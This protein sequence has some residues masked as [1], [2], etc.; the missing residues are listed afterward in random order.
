[1]IA[2][3]PNCSPLEPI[4]KGSYTSFPH[5]K[6][7]SLRGLTTCL[8]ALSK[9]EPDNVPSLLLIADGIHDEQGRYIVIDFPLTIIGESKDGCTI[10]GGL[11]MK[12]K[13]EDDVTV[14]HLTISQSK[15]Y[16]VYGDGGM[17]FHL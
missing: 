10:I 1:M 14:K 5:P 17:S 11:T 13:K 15:S 7:A 8:N 9:K 16:G 12:G 3:N 2:Y 6:Y 4:P